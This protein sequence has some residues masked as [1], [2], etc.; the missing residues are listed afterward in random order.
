MITVALGTFIFGIFAGLGLGRLFCKQH[1]KNDAVEGGCKTENTH[2]HGN[3][4]AGSELWHDCSPGCTGR[5]ND[6]D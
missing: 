4:S 6:Q 5:C 3:H 1:H 2:E